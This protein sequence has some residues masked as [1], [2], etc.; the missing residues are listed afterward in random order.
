MDS[1]GVYLA[2]KPMKNESEE[3]DRLEIYLINHT[4]QPLLFSYELML[5]NKLT[6]KV[7]NKISENS[8]FELNE[9]FVEQLNDY[10]LLNLEFWSETKNKE[11][12]NYF[13]KTLKIKAQTFFKKL[14]QAPVLNENAYLFYLFTDFPEAKE[15]EKTFPEDYYFSS[16]KKIKQPTNEVIEQANWQTE[17]DLHIEQLIKN[18]SGMSNAEIIKIQLSRF[19]QF[20]E[21]AFNK[22]I[23]KIYVIHGVGKGRLREE[24]HLLLQEYPEVQSFNNNYHHK[25][26]FGATEIF[27]S[28]EEN[29]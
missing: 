10:P 18:H 26:G 5:N 12:E 4:S 19:R 25:Y 15:K 8:I 21:K 13:Q 27:L 11:Q 22:S 7:S 3:I 17:I 23:P 24:I 2:F 1:K 16:S 20:L 14:Q 6:A 9:I 28:F 29:P